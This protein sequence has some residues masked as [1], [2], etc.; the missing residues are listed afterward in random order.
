MIQAVER[1][2]QIL[3]LAAGGA[4][5]MRLCDISRACGLKRNTVFNLA[6]TLVKEGLLSK[7]AEGRYSAGHLLSELAAKQSGCGRRRAVE[8]FL[9]AL[10]LRYPGS[11]I[12]YSELSGTNVTPLFNFRPSN[13][14]RIIP[15]SGETLPLYTSVAGLVFLAFSSRERADW[16]MAAHPFDFRGLE[17][18][19][20]AERL[21]SQLEAAR[22]SGYS[23]TP[24]ITAK[25]DMKIGLP[26]WGGPGTLS[27]AVTFHCYNQKTK[28][29]GAEILKD[30]FESAE[31]AQILLKG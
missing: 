23:E 29:D 18:W 14:G 20:G 26:V 28:S 9:T 27:G 12:Y 22:R 31:K 24:G 3:R 8:N 10:H 15:L 7:T 1:A 5:G 30:I 25:D 21:N 13:P 2:V 19:G 4:D 6:E 16:L 11:A 17:A